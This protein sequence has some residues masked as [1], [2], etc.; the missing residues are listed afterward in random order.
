MPEL[1]LSVVKTVIDVAD[2]GLL[3]DLREHVYPDVR[4]KLA[5]AIET[6]DNEMWL[7]VYVVVR[8]LIGSVLGQESMA[9]EVTKFLEQATSDPSFAARATRLLGEG[10]RTPTRRRRRMLALALFAP[11]PDTDVRDRVDMAVEK[12]TAADVDCLRQLVDA[13][14]DGGF[15]LLHRGPT[16]TWSA[17]PTIDAISAG[18]NPGARAPTIALSVAALYALRGADCVDISVPTGLADARDGGLVVR[19]VHVLPLGRA[20]LD[21]LKDE[22]AI[23]DIDESLEAGQRGVPSTP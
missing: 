12:L 1:K 18:H 11:P 20:V 19:D 5:Q 13:D 21:V 7:S 9:A 6:S 10:L 14:V 2:P 22:R 17:R 16:R 3:H 4:A 15:K 8:A 23:A